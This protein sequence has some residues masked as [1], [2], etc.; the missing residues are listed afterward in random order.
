MTHLSA[1][2]QQWP[3]YLRKQRRNKDKKY[4][5]VKTGKENTGICIKLPKVS[6]DLYTGKE[7]TTCLEISAGL[8]YMIMVA[9][10][11]PLTTLGYLA[12]ELLKTGKADAFAD[13]FAF[14]VCMLEVAN[15]RRPTEYGKLNLVDLVF[16]CWKRG[17][18]LDV[19]EPRLEVISTRPNM[20]QVLQYLYGDAK[21][22][23]IPLDRFIVSVSAAST[24]AYH[25]LGCLV[26]VLLT[27]CVNH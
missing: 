4:E 12:P 3:H 21:F 18:I 16:D 9:F 8:G 22:P 17:S 5:E 20:S 1:S 25:S 23:D 14:G 19:T 11:R 13:V 24:E 7:D 27:P 26:L 10:H 6:R 15:G 2:S